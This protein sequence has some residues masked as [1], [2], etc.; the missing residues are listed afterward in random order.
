MNGRGYKNQIGTQKKILELLAY[1]TSVKIATRFTPFH[2]VY[3]LAEV[4][5]IECEI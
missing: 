2:L 3:C 5:S 4:L 1:R